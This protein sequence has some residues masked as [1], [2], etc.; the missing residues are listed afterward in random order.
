L[1]SF[2]LTFNLDS[3]ERVKIVRSLPV[4]IDPE[5]FYFWNSDLVPDT[6]DPACSGCVFI[7]ST[8]SFQIMARGEWLR[9]IV[10][11]PGPHVSCATAE[12]HLKDGFET[13]RFAVGCRSWREAFEEPELGGADA[14]LWIS[15]NE[16]SAD[17][18]NDGPLVFFS[19]KHGVRGFTPPAYDLPVVVDLHAPPVLSQLEWRQLVQSFDHGNW[20]FQSL[21][22]LAWELLSRLRLPRMLIWVRQLDFSHVVALAALRAAFP[23]ASIALRI[24]DDAVLTPAQKRLVENLGL[25]LHPTLVTHFSDELSTFEEISPNLLLNESGAADH[26]ALFAYLNR[27]VDL[28]PK[29]LVPA[30][31]TNGSMS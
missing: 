7:Q 2:D 29:S 25:V 20:Q 19:R 15:R 22:N 11:Q 4:E 17:L 10:V 3:F 1:L 30:P 23:E 24:P 16:L 31:A 13:W 21:K 6:I 9:D 18:W 8:A 26:S 5:A 14:V 27:H 12:V 28:V